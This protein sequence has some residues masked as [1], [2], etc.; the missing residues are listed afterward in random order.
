MSLVYTTQLLKVKLGHSLF[1]S[2]LTPYETKVTLGRHDR[3]RSDV[4]EVTISV[5][6]I[7]LHSDYGA[8]RRAHDLALIRLSNRVTFSSWILPACLPSPGNNFIS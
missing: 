2:R 6:E 3:C 1:V 7:I 5:E 4:T 8:S